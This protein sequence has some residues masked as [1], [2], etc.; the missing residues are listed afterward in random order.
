M[1]GIRKN[2]KYTEYELELP[3]GATLFVYTDGVSEATDSSKTL[4]GTDRMLEALNKK[5][6]ASPERLLGN[7]HTAVNEFV[8]DAPQFDD[9]TMLA[10]K[11]N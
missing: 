5:P 3:K 7:V 1:I 6:D 11:I 9:L 8:G 10:I 2:K 4:F